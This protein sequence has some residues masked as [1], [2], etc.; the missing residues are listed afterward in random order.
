MLEK[1]ALQKKMI[2]KDDCLKAM[3]ACKSSPNYEMAL[4]SYFIE[5]NLIPEKTILQLINTFDSIKI[6]KTTMKFGTVAVKMGFISQNIL[7]AALAIQKKTVAANQKPKLIGQILVESGKLTKDQIAL[8]V[9]KQKKLGLIADKVASPQQPNNIKQTKPA[10]PS[11]NTESVKPVVEKKVTIEF[12]D[13][14]ETIEGG[15][16]LDIEDGGMTAYLRKTDTFDSNLTIDDIYSILLTK[17]IQ[18]GLA[19]DDAINGFINSSG[20][21][22]NRFKVASGTERV[23]GKDA[24]IEY[25]FDT[26]HLKA[27]GMDD[28]GNIDFKDRGKIPKTETNTLLAEKFPLKKATMGRD[29]FGNELAITPVKDI[30]L[31]A[32]TGVLISEDGQHAYSEISGHPKLSWSGN[33]SVVDTFIA[34]ADVGYETGHL[35]YDGNIEVKGCLKSGFCVTGDDIKIK[36]I[37]GGEIH[38]E[39]DV[40]ILEGVN[41]AKIFSRGNVTANFIH[42]S[43]ISC[44]GDVFIAREIVDSTIQASGSC[45]VKTGKIINS[46]I[47]SNQGVIAKDIGTDKT[48]SNTIIVGQDLFIKKELIH[49][50]KQIIDT[51]KQ[52]IKSEKRRQSLK[53]ENQGFQQSTARIAN[54]LDKV[55]DEKQTIENEM[56]ELE[57][58]ADAKKQYLSLK[59]TLKQTQAFFSRLDKQLNDL[60]NNIGKNDQ[61]IETIEETF[62]SFD[63]RL[64]DLKYERENYID[65]QDTNPGQSI[66]IASGQ[67]CSGS[68]IQGQHAQKEI[69]ET[70]RNVQIKECKLSGNVGNTD[71]YEIQIHDNV[72]KR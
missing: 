15:M 40:V 36:E 65:W 50:E 11:K 57:N 29:I 70:E 52:K 19:S 39:G 20:F 66:V 23:F 56:A 44:L 9:Q 1:L 7:K 31:K 46:Q 43:Q 38:A 17:S 22:T 26:D 41:G 63:D 33:L 48:H 12:S 5:N 58:Q 28:D 55:L 61:I 8:I 62:D 24:R 27:G 18:Y 64:E 53:I 16:A 49:I 2:S 45:Q 13:E 60:F 54:E 34:K 3:K 47:A 71:L 21:R 42:D 25:F 35:V 14:S 68:I 10:P 6:M 51:E 59:T 4:K 69:K 67:V 37:D 32:T 72:K 30:F